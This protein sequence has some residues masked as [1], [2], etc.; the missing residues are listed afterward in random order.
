MPSWDFL[1]VQWLRHC[2]PD[3]RG[4]GSVPGQGA[5]SHKLQPKLLHDARGIKDLVFCS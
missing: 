2:T 1:V 5:R 4:L 3:A